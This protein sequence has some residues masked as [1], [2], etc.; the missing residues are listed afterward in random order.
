MPD[1]RDVKKRSDLSRVKLTLESVRAEWAHLVGKHPDFGALAVGIKAAHDIESSPAPTLASF[2]AMAAS[3]KAPVVEAGTDLDA[4]HL[5][6]QATC[7]R[8]GHV[9]LEPSTTNT[10]RDKCHGAPD[11]RQCTHEPR[12]LVRL[13]PKPA[14]RSP[15]KSLGSPS[16]ST[17]TTTSSKQFRLE[18]A[19]PSRAS[20]SSSAEQVALVAEPAVEA[21]VVVSQTCAIEVVQPPVVKQPAAAGGAH[22]EDEDEDLVID[23]SQPVELAPGSRAEP[24]VIAAPREVVVE[25]AEVVE[26]VAVA[27]AA[28]EP[29]VVD[30]PQPVELAPGSRA[31]PLVVAPP[32]P[33]IRVEDVGAV[34]LAV[35]ELA[36]APPMSDDAGAPPPPEVEPAADAPKST[37]QAAFKAARRGKPTR[38]QADARLRKERKARR[39]ARNA[40]AAAPGIR[41]ATS[42]PS[43]DGM[44]AVSVPAAGRGSGTRARELGSTATGGRGQRDSSALQLMVSRWIELEYERRAALGAA[45][46]GLVDVGEQWLGIDGVEPSAVE[47]TRSLVLLAAAESEPEQARITAGLP[48][49][50]LRAYEAAQARAAGASGVGLF[51]LT[52]TQVVTI[53]VAAAAVWAM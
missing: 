20:G 23:D 7:F 34:A 51:G 13:E 3:E 48:S 35:A 28:V 27:H 19:R 11:Q 50:A 14:C 17:R 41:C 12:C 29:A 39:E 15:R 36:V 46:C 21:V 16:K 2:A 38:K 10:S 26:V 6:G 45:E 25:V 32:V 18:L 49:R 22:A 47:P 53:A 30:E 40:A 44:L 8:R 42:P 1:T 4:S 52:T 24:L 31:E 37:L 43:D 5:C 9:V 33:E